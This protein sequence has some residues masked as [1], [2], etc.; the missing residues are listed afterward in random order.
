MLLICARFGGRGEGGLL[1]LL[2]GQTH[3]SETE[4]PLISPARA[5]PRGVWVRHAATILLTAV[6]ARIVGYACVVRIR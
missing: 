1:G 2:L 4:P 6:P 5:A 3:P